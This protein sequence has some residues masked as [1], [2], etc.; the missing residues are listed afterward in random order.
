[1]TLYILLPAFNEG[2]NL[3]HL[4]NGIIEL[5]SNFPQ[6]I[7][8]II[9]DD[10]S[11]DNTK[12]V[13]EDYTGR[14]EVEILK[15]EKNKGL[16]E[17]LKTGLLSISRRIRDEDIL[18]IMDADNSHS[19]E[20]IPSL[21]NKLKEGYDVAI[22]SRF[23]AG[24]MTYGVPFFRRVITRLSSLTFRIFF[25]AC[26]VLDF[27]C[28]YRAYSGRCILNYINHYKDEIIT[29]KSF[30][31]MAEICLKIHA[32][33]GKISEVPFELHYER[34][35]GKSKMPFVRTILNILKLLFKIRFG[36]R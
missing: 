17:A 9:V 6:Q 22:A 10:G 16:G 23:A 36:R 8:T 3:P 35:K 18:V 20:Y 19:P 24:G 28:G 13:C 14:L 30:S 4:L 26:K 21:Y 7:K 34:K 32:L 1:M 31:A 15:H 33:G 5:S 12:A 11:T 29:D 27:T 25:P 2:E